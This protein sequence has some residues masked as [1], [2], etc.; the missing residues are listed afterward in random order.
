MPSFHWN[1]QSQTAQIQKRALLLPQEVARLTEDEE[2]MF[3]ASAPAFLLRKLRWYDDPRFRDL[4][5]KPP[6]LPVVS[7]TLAWD[8]G[9][10]SVT[11]TKLN[12][13]RTGKHDVEG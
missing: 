8:D 6:A 9:T 10:V 7:Y 13:H 5:A 12:T 4:E 2:L 3:R 1:R 11:A